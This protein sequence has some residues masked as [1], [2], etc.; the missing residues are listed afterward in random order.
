MIGLHSAMQGWISAARM[1]AR[2][3]DYASLRPRNNCTTDNSWTAIFSMTA[4]TS[5]TQAADGLPPRSVLVLGAC[6]VDGAE[7]Q[8]GGG[9]TFRVQLPLAR[10]NPV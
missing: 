3:T 6:E 5:A 10:S 9:S 7:S 1:L 4:G 2:W 8:E